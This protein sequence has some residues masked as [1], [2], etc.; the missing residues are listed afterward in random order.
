MK[1]LI[2]LGNKVFDILVKDHGEDL[3]SRTLFL[4]A[5]SVDSPQ[6]WY[7]LGSDKRVMITQSGVSISFQDDAIS[8]LNLE[9]TKLIDDK[10]AAQA[11][12]VLSKI[13]SQN[14]S[15]KDGDTFNF[16]ENEGPWKEIKL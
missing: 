10:K 13:K 7:V 14:F 9:W 2:D 15:P 3:T 11:D 5:I 12:Q 1:D 16:W 8:S 4:Y 6:P